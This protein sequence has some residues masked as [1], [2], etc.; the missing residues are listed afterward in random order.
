MIDRA[1]IFRDARPDDAEELAQVGRETFA[2]TFGHLYAPEN[3]RTY[4][5]ETYTIGLMRA[6]IA[7]PRVDIRI[8][9]AG[10]RMVAYCKVG[11]LKLPIDPGPG[12]VL[13]L[14][15]VYVYQARQGVGVGRILLNW[16]ISRA[17]ERGAKALYLGVYQGN[18]RAIAVYRSRGFETVGTYK[19]RVG[20]TM[21]DE[22][23]MR[24]QLD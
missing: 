18:E 4:L 9:E 21:D 3:L 1:L 11:P 24:L 14:H 2:E 23:I 10:R 15:R 12:P 22:F 16:A 5:D 6:D 17:R 19:F 13:E 7:D 8:A 20:Q